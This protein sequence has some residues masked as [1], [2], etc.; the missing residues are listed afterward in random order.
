MTNSFS[1][2]LM[3][4]FSP[5]DIVLFCITKG[6]DKFGVNKEKEMKVC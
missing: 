4:A 5:M 1:M 6:F 3:C 2:V